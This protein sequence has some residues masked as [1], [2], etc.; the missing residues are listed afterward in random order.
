MLLADQLPRDAL[1]SGGLGVRVRLRVAVSIIIRGTARDL[2]GS[3]F[4]VLF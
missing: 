4:G 3:G 1:G 2:Y